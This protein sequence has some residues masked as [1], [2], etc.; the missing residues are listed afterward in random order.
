MPDG[1]TIPSNYSVALVHARLGCWSLR[2][3]VHY[4]YTSSATLNRDKLEAEAEIASRDV[5][6]LLNPCRN[7]LNSSR[8]DN[9]DTPART[10]H[11]HADRPAGRINGKTAFS[12]LPHAQIE[13]DPSID[14]AATQGPPWACTARHHAQ[15]C[16]RRAVIGTHCYSER[17]DEYWFCLKLNWRQVRAFNTQ[18]RDVGS[19]ITSD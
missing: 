3:H 14:L 11:R 19:M 6:V 17:A 10:E 12:T 16:S 2:L 5:A 1:L 15:C 7:A 4:H 8:R 13:F 18:Q 9:E